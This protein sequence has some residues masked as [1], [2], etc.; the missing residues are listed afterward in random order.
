MVTMEVPALQFR[1]EGEVWCY[2]NP[3]A[4]Y[5]VSLPRAMSAASLA[6][7]RTASTQ[8]GCENTSPR[9]L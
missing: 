1:F 4:V 9:E 5:F 3:N 8:T 7:V 6:R 2:R